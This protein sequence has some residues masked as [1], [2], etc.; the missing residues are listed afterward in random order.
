[1]A[2]EVPWR[3]TSR[4]KSPFGKPVR[5]FSPFARIREQQPNHLEI[6]R[7]EMF[8]PTRVEDAW[9]R[10]RR[11]APL[12]LRVPAA[13]NLDAIYLRH[14]EER[15]YC[16]RLHQ[17]QVLPSLDAVSVRLVCFN[18]PWV[19]Y[20]W[21]EPPR[22]PELSAKT[23]PMTGVAL[24]SPWQLREA[25]VRHGTGD[26][27]RLL[28][29][30]RTEHR[31]ATNTGF[32]VPLQQVEFFD[33]QQGVGDACYGPCPPWW[34]EAWISRNMSVPLPPLVTYKASQLLHRMSKTPEGRFWRLVFE[35]EWTVLFFARWCSD[36]RQRKLMWRLPARLRENLTTMGVDQ[37]FLDSEFPLP[38]VQQWLTEH[39]TYDWSSQ[40]RR[41]RMADPSRD[42]PNGVYQDLVE[43]ARIFDPMEATLEAVEQLKP[44]SN[45]PEG[46]RTQDVTT[47]T[48]QDL[49]LKTPGCTR[50]CVARRENT[51][52]RIRSIP[53]VAVPSVSDHS[54][55]CLS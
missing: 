49:L 35:S 20:R 21:L 33:Q 1:M 22:V 5:P 10:R 37:L 48:D 25:S 19:P 41:Y 47:E 2:D 50:I 31:M 14:A 3:P 23:Y 34:E 43:F 53:A 26:S 40:R 16:E 24:D 42:N 17:L 11:H 39:D 44:N 8:G 6:E 54:N 51:R 38:V 52:V 36:I 4:R 29:E 55:S 15:S 45:Q 18:R 12:D 28:M 32:L 30:G 46:P 9:L 13:W 27:G 7:F